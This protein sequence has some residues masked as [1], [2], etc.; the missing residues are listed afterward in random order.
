MKK[1]KE[2]ESSLD[3]TLELEWERGEERGEKWE[4]L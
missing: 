2:C 4:F 1:R 3:M